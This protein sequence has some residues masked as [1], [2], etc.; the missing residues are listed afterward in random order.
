[1]PFAISQ[2]STFWGILFILCSGTASALGL[3]F[4]GLSSSFVEPAKSSFFSLSLVTHPA[5]SVVF[6][7]AIAVKCFGVGVSYLIVV[8]Q[9]MPQV[10]KYFLRPAED[11][12]F[13]YPIFESKVVWVTA[14]LIVAGPLSFAR[15]LESLKYTSIVALASVGY[16]VVLVLVKFGQSVASADTTIDKDTIDTLHTWRPPSA[17]GVLSVLPVL[18]FAFTCHQNMFASINEL[19]LFN[20]A[21]LAKHDPS[22][23]SDPDTKLSPRI[24]ERT[25]TKMVAASIYPAAVTYIAVG[26]A[27]Y[28]TFGNGIQGNIMTMYEYSLS[29]VI[30]RIAIVVMVLFSY[31]LQLHPCRASISNIIHWFTTKHSDPKGAD[32]PLTEMYPENSQL[33]E[34]FVEPQVVVDKPSTAH[35][36][37][38]SHI[39]LVPY[40]AITTTILLLSFLLAIK[41]DSLQTVLA[42]VGATG[43]TSI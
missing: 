16:L 2:T 15:H 28:L 42:F 25:L 22:A 33:L 13:E 21:E 36:V 20:Q 29:T 23:T 9:L 8:A 31:P 3:Y 12:I 24:S 30:G 17:T 7:A 41:V 11:E 39:P 38:D 6:D 27:G 5:L 43:S 1:M 37:H 40:V 19:V 10:V 32:M 18:V 14:A 4:Q 35:L 26:V 34:E